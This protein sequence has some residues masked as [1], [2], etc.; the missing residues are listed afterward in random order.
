MLSS[1]TQLKA[2]LFPAN[3]SSVTTHDTLLTHLGNAAQALVEKYLAR[4]ITRTAGDTQ[5]F[6]GDLTLLQLARFPVET[7]TAL[8][9]QTED[10]GTWEDILDAAVR[11]GKPTGLITLSGQQGVHT[12]TI[13]ATF[14][15]GFYV[16]TSEN[17]SGSL[18]S[19]ATAL[20]DDLREAWYQVTQALFN[21]AQNAAVQADQIDGDKPAASATAEL[22]T[23]AKVLLEKY[24][25]LVA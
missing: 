22:P 11:V 2:R 6:T 18:P 1:L 9:I 10:G 20:P 5:T 17:Q 23:L 14:T 19:G 3:W 16:D 8:D 21:T 15:G 4:K 25:V 12:D 24:R 13:R 7:L